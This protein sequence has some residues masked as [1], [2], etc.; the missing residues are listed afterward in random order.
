MGGPCQI[1]IDS[2]SEDQI[3]AAAQAAEAEVRRLDAKYSNY[4]SDSFTQQIND[5]A[6]RGHAIDIDEETSAL[7]N[8][9]D[10]LWQQSEGLFDL[11]AGVLNQA[12]DFK[13]NA[14]PQNKVLDELLPLVGW[15]QLKLTDTSLE[16]PSVGMYLDFGGL[17]KEYASDRAAQRLI[18]HGCSHS[19]VELA[20]DICVCG[21]QEDG[22][23]WPI[24][25]RH[26][27]SPSQALAD[28]QLAAGA[29]ASS[30]DYERGMTIDGKRY[31]HILHPKTGWPVEGLASVSIV[32]E[33]CLVAG[34]LATVALLKPEQE[35]MDWLQS[36]GMPWL[37]VN[38]N[39]QVFGSLS[40]Q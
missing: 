33:Q 12:W 20:G 40:D 11:T 39:L 18:E 2:H 32:A 35:A 6:G 25:I 17:V 26:P 10:T 21:P 38:Q 15:H 24:G 4:R 30:G 28:I 3:L 31:G 29:L 36:L 13:S 14:L 34:S 27:T 5:S 23:E 9:A 22:I 1:Q 37:A 19:L 8:Y 16:L 7:L